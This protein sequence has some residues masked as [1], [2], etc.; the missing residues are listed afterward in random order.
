MDAQLG[1]GPEARPVV[2]K[3]V[4]VGAVKYM[5]DSRLRR[6]LHDDGELDLLAAIAPVGRILRHC[7]VDRFL[8]QEDVP[9]A[10]GSGKPLSLLELAYGEH[11]RYHGYRNGI[12]SQHIVRYP[13]EKR[14]VHSSRI[15][16]RDSAHR[17]YRLT[18]VLICLVDS[19]CSPPK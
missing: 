1:K 19:P 7:R 13:T 11:G 3:V 2:R 4:Q 5:D 8:M 14:A 17:A 9:D 18:K 15:G 12:V 10:D 16:N 6:G